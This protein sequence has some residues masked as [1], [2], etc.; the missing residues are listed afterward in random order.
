MIRK[1]KNCGCLF[2]KCRNQFGVTK[3]YTQC[4]NCRELTDYSFMTCFYDSLCDK[5]EDALKK[6]NRYKEHKRNKK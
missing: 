6:Y 5:I 1:C 3:L 2:L 4:P